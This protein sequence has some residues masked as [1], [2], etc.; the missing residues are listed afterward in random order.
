VSLRVMDAGGASAVTSQTIMV[1][2]RP[3]PAPQLLT[4]FPIVRIAG[5]ATSTGVKLRLLTAEAPA[6]STVALT[7]RGRG[8]PR[9][10]ERRVAPGRAGSAS[11]RLVSFPRFAHSLRSGVVLEIRVTRTG[12]IGKYTRFIV[13]RNK[14]PRRTDS[15]L[16]P[17]VS[18]PKRC[19]A[20]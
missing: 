14:A 15:C 12:R 3:R 6:G 13:R 17:G 18:S 4:P 10:R 5:R 2:L 1:A 11:L 8:C 7:C 19:P 9:A 20:S 16:M